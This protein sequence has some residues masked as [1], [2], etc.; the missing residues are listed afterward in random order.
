[1]IV[2]CHTHTW[3]PDADLG[4]YGQGNPH[5]RPPLPVLDGRSASGVAMHL[6]SAEPVDFTIVLGFKSRYLGVELSND[7][8]AEYV[9]G[10]PDELI[11][12]AGIDP[13]DPKEALEELDRAQRSLGLVG[14][15]VAPAAQDFHP[16]NSQAMQVYAE[17]ARR[18]LPVVFHQGI[19]ITS[20]TKLEYAHP[21]LLDEIA[22]EYP[23]LRMVI[24]H[25]G[26]PWVNETVTLLAKHAHVYADVSW[27]TRHTW[28]AYRAL[29]A[30]HELGVMGK[31]LFGSGFPFF[32]AARSIESLY[33]VNHL[34]HGTHLPTIPRES[35]R[36]I[37][38]RDALAC[39]GLPGRAIPPSEKHPA[40][41]DEPDLLESPDLRP[42]RE[43]VP[44]RA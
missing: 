17:A 14:L 42:Q 23:E 12:F 21:V 7:G 26:F 15:A 32:S 10:H 1:M 27:I 9:R 33:S 34:A 2:D 18:R 4:P 22:R 38:E 30:A 31:L 40:H 41:D 6:A 29:L 13:S 39:L 16:T 44:R 35:L 36:G 20:P 19:Q 11:G 3:E 5:N 24:A 8:V 28:E 43:D 37:V 25:M